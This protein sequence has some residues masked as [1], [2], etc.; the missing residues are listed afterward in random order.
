MD[1]Q[2]FGSVMTP[3]IL[4]VFMRLIQQLAETPP[5]VVETTHD[6][7]GW[8]A[9]PRRQFRISQSLKV[10]QGDDLAVLRRQCPE[11]ILELI[12]STVLW[13]GNQLAS[14]WIDSHFTASLANVELLV[15]SVTQDDIE[16]RIEFAR[17]I[18]SVDRLKG[19]E[20]RILDT[21]QRV[22]AVTQNC[23]RM[24]ERFHLISLNQR[25]ERIPTT[26]PTLLYHISVTL[27]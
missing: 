3:P 4:D 24:P 13:G 1:S 19:G 12:N 27:H 17:H 20:K 23:E 5:R 7:T 10:P 11:R 14:I 16:P 2:P 25:A 26:R 21:V 8:D 22:L 9:Q 15:A 18:K 6:R